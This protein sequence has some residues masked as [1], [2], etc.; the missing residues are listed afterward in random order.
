MA[1]Q[2]RAKP[3]TNGKP[4]TNPLRFAALIRV[5]TDRQEEQGESLR[6]QRTSIA[7]SVKSLGGKIIEWYG[8][9]EHATPGWEK[10]EVDRLL[11]DATKDRWDAVI[12]ATEWRWSR[13]NVKC[14]QGID[15]LLENDKRFFVRTAEYE[16][17]D[18]FKRNMLVQIATIGKLNAAVL[19]KAS[20]ESR[21]ARS[22]RGIPT[23]GRL[24]FGRTY[25]EKKS[26]DPRK[27][28]G[29]DQV[30][31]NMIKDVAKR[32]LA[33]ESLTVLAKEYGYRTS[34]YLSEVMR[35]RCS[36]TWVETFDYPMFKIHADVTHKI[37]RLLPDRTIEA[38]SKEAKKRRAYSDKRR[39]YDYLL[40]SR[41]FCAHC[42]YRMTGNAPSPQYNSKKR[43]YRHSRNR[44]NPCTIPKTL[45]EANIVE[46]AVLRRLFETFGNVK[47]VER[48]IKAAIPNQGEVI[49]LR[50]QQVKV[51]QALVKVE[52]AKEK[53][54][55]AIAE[56]VITKG[57]AKVKME[58]LRAREAEHKE[59]LHKIKTALEHLPSEDTVRTISEKTV[60]RLQ[61]ALYPTKRLDRRIGLVEHQGNGKTRWSAKLAMQ[62]DDLDQP[63]D[64]EAVINA[65]PWEEQRGLIE[66][67]FSAETADGR[68]S[69]VYIHW[70][71]VK[72]EDKPRWSYAIRGIVEPNI[73]ES[74]TKTKS[75]I[76]NMDRKRFA[77]ALCLPSCKSPVWAVAEVVRLPPV[78]R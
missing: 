77:N 64:V 12:I 61:A 65:M 45:I 24:P 19:S 38:I 57:D 25:D 7:E 54:V 66:T 34:S 69:G 46:R 17:H 72:G 78:N 74:K 47:A 52:Q 56:G 67:V 59:Q 53:V 30:K 4:A 36:D 8:G 51:E 75:Q 9:S 16:L 20:I 11:R 1:R 41:I 18:P 73:S 5:S 14:E 63:E 68:P 40:N 31:H 10:D 43:Y 44:Q 26:T 3:S 39:K 2:V 62:V 76:R 21:V 13:D 48:A 60:A 55:D 29:L 42:G 32:Y 22:K 6:V 28:W 70:H 15:I 33:G 49:E 71:Q 23:S 58:R 50:A 27:C 37:P 35:E